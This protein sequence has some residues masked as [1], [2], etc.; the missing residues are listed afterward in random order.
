L[1]GRPIDI[2]DTLIAGI[3]A[4]RRAQLATRNVKHFEALKVAVIDPWTP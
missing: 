3:A 1:R 2:R 4:S